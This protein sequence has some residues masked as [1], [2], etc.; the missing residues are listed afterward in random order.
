[1]TAHTGWIASLSNGDTR[2]ET[3]PLPGEQSAWQQ[4]RQE[5]ANSE[6]SLTR[7]R[8]QRSGVTIVALSHKTCDGYFQAYESHRVLFRDTV[9][10]MQGIGSVIGDHV[11]ITWVDDFGNITQDVRNLDSVKV[12]TAI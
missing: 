2:L 12:H 4:L 9:K 10:T 3:T 8:L 6:H 7:L 11:Y 1:M 5:L